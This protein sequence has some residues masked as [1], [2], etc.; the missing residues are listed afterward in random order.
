MVPFE[1]MLRR[2][3]TPLVNKGGNP[4]MILNECEGDC[5]EDCDGDLRCWQRDDWTTP[6][7]P[8]C[9]GA[10]HESGHDYCWNPVRYETTLVDKRL[11]PE[12]PLGLCEGDCD[13][14]NDNVVLP[15]IGHILFAVP[16]TN[17][18]SQHIAAFTSG[19]VPAL[20]PLF[21]THSVRWMVAPSV[22]TQFVGV[23][24]AQQ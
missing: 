18:S 6:I 14:D 22:C 23:R 12:G 16:I 11:D 9:E 17:I 5:D 10:P 8:G 24:V 2:T 3:I 4:N 7:P 21:I 1:E 15:D 13:S 20:L 19:Q